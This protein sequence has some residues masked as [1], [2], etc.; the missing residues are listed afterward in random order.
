LDL[1]IEPTTKPNKKEEN[2]SV[3]KM[4]LIIT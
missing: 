3:I 2:G 4:A 1:K